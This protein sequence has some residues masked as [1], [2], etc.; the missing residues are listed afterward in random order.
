MTARGC[1]GLLGS[2]FVAE[3][4][5]RRRARRQQ[6]GLL[7]AEG[8]LQAA[9]ALFGE[10]GYDKTTTSMIATRAGTSPGSLY[11]LFP[12]KEAIAQAYA[13]QAVARLHQVYDRIL[14]P[15]VVT[16][17]FRTF[18]D[19]FIDALIAVNRENPG[20]LALLLASTM[21]APL[22]GIFA[23]LQ[24]GVQERLSA[25]MAARFPQQTALQRQLHG[26]IT[27]RVFAA[28]LPLILTG[29]EEQ[30]AAMVCELK[31]ILYRYLAPRTGGLDGVP[32]A[33][34]SANLPGLNQGA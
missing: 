30:Q 24:E 4:E 16:L 22:A 19:S 13:A 14:A 7:R 21:S 26:R 18:L 32:S 10:V 28:L 33:A 15:P 12:N 5:A 20:L 2:A 17:P 1:P 25:V 34:A 3:N 27:Y 6:R 29:D 9:G 11:Q 23:E 31:T 8:I